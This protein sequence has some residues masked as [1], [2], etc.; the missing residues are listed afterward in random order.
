M[1][2]RSILLNQMFDGGTVFNIP[3]LRGPLCAP[4]NA[5]EFEKAIRLMH[6]KHATALEFFSWD[7]EQRTQQ[8][9]V[10]TPVYA[11]PTPSSGSVRPS[12]PQRSETSSQVFLHA[13][14]VCIDTLANSPKS[15]PTLQ[16]I[17]NIS[18][19][20]KALRGQTEGQTASRT[21]GR[22]TSSSS[23]PFPPSNIPLQEHHYQQP[24]Q[25]RPT[26]AQP[27]NPQAFAS[28]TTSR[29]TI[30]VT[31]PAGNFTY[32]YFRFDTRTWW[33]IPSTP[34]HAVNSAYID[35]S[36]HLKLGNEQAGSQA[37]NKRLADFLNVCVD[38]KR[39]LP[40]NFIFC[41]W[42]R[43][44]E[45]SGFLEQA[46]RQPGWMRPVIEGMEVDEDEDIYGA[47]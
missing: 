25:R 4:H 12:P 38:M 24:S 45:N 5:R 1:A 16:D 44:E 6:E 9:I 8:R 14:P 30:P 27:T 35:R 19:A 13:S 17:N 20:R 26:T 36:R 23:P 2:L 34:S 33:L 21:Q 32:C 22:I 3:L 40:S 43:L 41:A 10:S 39:L 37:N 11:P 28:A 15:L 31:I 46:L 18:A 47:N 29:V 42:M 7:A